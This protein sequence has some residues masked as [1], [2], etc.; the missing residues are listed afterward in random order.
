MMWLAVVAFPRVPFFWSSRKRRQQN[1]R[2][3]ATERP[4]PC[5]LLLCLGDGQVPLAR[6]APLTSELDCGLPG[7]GRC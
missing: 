5:A 2:A 1:T 4:T 7:S 6:M 3:A